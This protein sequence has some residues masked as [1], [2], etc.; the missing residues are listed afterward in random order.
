MTEE[1]RVRAKETSAAR[2]TPQQSIATPVVEAWSTFRHDR[3]G[4]KPAVPGAPAGLPA[5]LG[6]RHGHGGGGGCAVARE[7]LLFPP[8][9]LSVEHGGG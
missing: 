5:F 7:D 3:R 9:R 4:C 8:P 2:V 6:E 1:T